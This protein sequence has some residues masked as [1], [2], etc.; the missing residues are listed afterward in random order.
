VG[1]KL[2]KI[3]KMVEYLRAYGEPEETID[4]IRAA[5]RE[6]KCDLPKI[7]AHDLKRRGKINA[8]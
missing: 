4:D 2:D 7:Y 5:Y 3:T 8:K 1:W 6:W